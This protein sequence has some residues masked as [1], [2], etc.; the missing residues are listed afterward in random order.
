MQDKDKDTL[1]D[2][3]ISVEREDEM[4]FTTNGHKR[5]TILSDDITK[6]GIGTLLPKSTL[7]INGNLNVTPDTGSSGIDFCKDTTHTDNYLHVILTNTQDKLDKSLDFTTNNGGFYKEIN[8]NLIESINNK[9]SLSNNNTLNLTGDYNFT[10]ADNSSIQ[11]NKNTSY[12]TTKKYNKTIENT[13][14]ETYQSNNTINI[15]N[16]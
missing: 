9:T 10:N 16:N 13:S 8:D 5:L 15:H 12:T 2:P 3:E 7:E 4:E 11:I 6:I 1:I 14:I